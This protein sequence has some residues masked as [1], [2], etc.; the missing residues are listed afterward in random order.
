MARFIR[1]AAVLAA[2]TA[3]LAWPALAEAP[4]LALTLTDGVIAPQ[5]LEIPAQ[6]ETVLRVTNAGTAPAELESKALHIET[7]I[8]PGQTADVALRALPEGSYAFVEEFH[9]DLDTARFTLLVKQ[10]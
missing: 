7:V 2:G 8:A 10:P 4:T 6:T 5:S 3:F 1:H 9:E